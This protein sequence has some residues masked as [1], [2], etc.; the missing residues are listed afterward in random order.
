MSNTHTHALSLILFTITLT[1]FVLHIFLTRPEHVDRHTEN[2]SCLERSVNQKMLS[3]VRVPFLLA[4]NFVK[5]L[6]MEF[7]HQITEAWC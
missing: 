3:L 7:Y 1:S 6:R 5:I 4:M 2:Q